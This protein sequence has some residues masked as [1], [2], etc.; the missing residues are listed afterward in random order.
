MEITET[1]SDGL[2][3]ELKVKIAASELNERLSKRL[4]ELKTQVNLKGFRPGKVPVDHLRK[5]YGR[6]V[7]AEILEQ[8]ISES[9]QKAIA[10]RKERPAFDPDI[11]VTEN[12]E[13]I[14][15]VIA[16][17]S[18]LDYTISFE[19]L[20]EIKL[21]DLTKLKL[22]KPVV[23]VTD[24]EVDNSLKRIHEDAVSYKKKDGKADDGDQVTIDY[25]GKIDGKAFDGGKAEDAPVVLGQGNFIPG[26][27]EG[28]KG[29]KAGDKKTI[30]C[31]FPKDYL[32]K[33]LA[34]KKA[35]FDVAV[36]QVAEPELAKLDDEFA[37]KLGYDTLAGLRD[38]VE[39]R[40]KEEYES[41]SKA[42]VKR[43]LLD[44]L[45][46]AHKFEV[47]ATLVEREFESVWQQVND[48][49]EKAGRTFEDEDTTEAKARK[50]YEELAERRVRLGLVLSEIGEKA[51]VKITDEEVNQALMER[52]QQFPGQERE[53]FEFYQKNPQAVAELRVPIFENKVVDH[54]LEQASV[55]DKKVS[56]DELLKAGEEDEAA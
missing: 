5:V 49:L 9:T 35:K 22:E 46:K 23:E 36:K 33:E 26:F 54:I 12:S 39:A 50:E 42:R 20:P 37:K 47:P 38:A 51:E 19:V 48:E 14:E 2:K 1:T 15:K 16:G 41:V 52:V 28:L 8:T 56:V 44:S 34:G 7:M 45:D 43:E 25:E 27:E 18:D 6:S 53:V 4:D 3:R 29:V 32:A 55:N 24:E 40:V 11:S 21:T 13:E 31:T 17:D 30:D 10:D